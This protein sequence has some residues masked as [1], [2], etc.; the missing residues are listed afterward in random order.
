MH[1]TQPL[2]V[3]LSRTI[4]GSFAGLWRV[5]KASRLLQ[6]ASLLAAIPLVLALFGI[7]YVSFDR[8]DLP[9][10]EAFIR[11]EPPTMGH[12]F[13]S[14]GRVLIELGKEHREIIQYDDIPEVL[15]HAIL[16]AEDKNFFSHWGVDYSV[17]PRLFAR[18]TFTP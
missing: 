18:Q 6:I 4:Q 3:R 11:F 14:N 15:R 7:A 16:S 10:L 13:D 17:F 12:I 2:P 8:R 5:Y 9:D 1:K